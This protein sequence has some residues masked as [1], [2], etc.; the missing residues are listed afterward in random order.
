MSPG[1]YRMH[2][3]SFFFCSSLTELFQT[4]HLFS[5]HWFYLLFGLICHSCTLLHFSFCLLNS[6][7]SEFLLVLFKIFLSIK[8]L[9]LFSC[10]DL[11]ELCFCVYFVLIEFLQRSYFE[12]FISYTALSAFEFSYRGLLYLCGCVYLMLYVPWSFALL[13]SHMN[14][15]L[16][17]SLPFSDGT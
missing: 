17:K 2:S 16:L 13:F 12:F 9:I 15:H 14:Q 10:P 4:I 3:F 5:D 8:F 7:D 1:S 6:S 11:T